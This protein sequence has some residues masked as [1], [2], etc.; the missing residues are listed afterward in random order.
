VLP[1]VAPDAGAV[2]PLVEP[3][4]GVV[5]TGV[6]DD[7]DELELTEVV[8]D[9]A[10]LDVVD[11]DDALAVVLVPVVPVVPFGD[12]EPLPLSS[13][14]SSLGVSGGTVE[15]VGSATVVPPHAAS[16]AAVSEAPSSATGRVSRATR[17]RPERAHATPAR[18]AVVEVAL[19]ELL[20]PRA[21]PEVLDRPR[22]LRVRR[23]ERQNLADDLE[24][25]AGL[26]IGVD[27]TGLGLDDHLA[28]GGR[29]P[30]A[31]AVTVSHRA[32]S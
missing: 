8:V 17:S 19:R 7:A 10:E 16:A 11:A 3:V 21:E 24:R 1:V 30:Q 2:P 26:A 13:E 27:A 9:A 12:V 20:A 23:R 18:R 15:G 31:I 6:V 25:L 32:R 14:L 4:L 5:V 29:G 28:T 22:Q